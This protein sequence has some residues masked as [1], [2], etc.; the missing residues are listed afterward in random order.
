MI[1]L[2]LGGYLT[3]AGG[4]AVYLGSLLGGEGYGYCIIGLGT[5]LVGVLIS[6]S[7]L[8]ACP[9]LVGKDFHY[10]RW[11]ILFTLAITITLAV[12][13]Y[14]RES[15]DYG[16]I[17]IVVFPFGALLMLVIALLSCVIAWLAPRLRP[18][19]VP[20]NLSFLIVL[21][22]CFATYLF[23]Q[24]W[25]PQDFE[26]VKAYVAVAAPALEKYYEKHGHYPDSINQLGLDIRVPPGLGYTHLYDSNH[27]WSSPTRRIG[28]EI[29]LIQYY[30]AE[31]CG[32]GQWFVD[33]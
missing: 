10:A 33:Y 30:Q 22:L 27:E 15:L 1:L 31:Y 7:L 3:L 4:I 17:V 11:A 25:W 18:C 13:W 32:D 24:A 28:D 20:T 9:N 8:Y 19:L 29:Y 26:Q 2:I 5:L 21:T 23:R 16:F 6:S 14:V 12:T